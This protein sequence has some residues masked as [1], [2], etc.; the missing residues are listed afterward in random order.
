MTPKVKIFKN[1]FRYV[2]RDSRYVAV[3]KLL[4]RRLGLVTGDVQ[5]APHFALTSPIAPTHFLI[6]VLGI[7][8]QKKNI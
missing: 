6:R 8:I 5:L 1:P 3:G 2:S 4:K 7:S